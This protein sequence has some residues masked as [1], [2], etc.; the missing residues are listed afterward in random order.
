M[1]LQE[2]FSPCLRPSQPYAL[3]CFDPYRIDKFLACTVKKK[4][5]KQ[6]YPH[7]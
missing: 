5:S 3:K 2:E 1:V 7:N 4:R 6:Q